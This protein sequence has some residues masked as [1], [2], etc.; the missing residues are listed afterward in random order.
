[1]ENNPLYQGQSFTVSSGVNFSPLSTAMPGAE[2]ALRDGMQASKTF[3]MLNDALIERN[4]DTFLRQQEVVEK[5]AAM[6]LTAEL[7]RGI[8]AQPGDKDSLYD[9][10][11]RVKMSAVN[12]LRSKYMEP[13]KYFQKGMISPLAIKKSQDAASSYQLGVDKTIQTA[14]LAAT[15]TK[16]EKVYRDSIKRDIMYGNHKS[17][18]ETNKRARENGVWSDDEA[19]MIQFDIN[20]GDAIKKINDCNGDAAKLLALYDDD[21]FQDSIRLHDKAQAKLNKAIEALQLKG[22]PEIVRYKLDSN[23]KPKAVVD[24]AKPPIGAPRYIQKTWVDYKGKFDTIEAKEAAFKTAERYLSEEITEPDT[25]SVGAEQWSKAKAVAESLGVDAARFKKAYDIRVSQISYGGFNPVPFVQEMVDE[26]WLSTTKRDEEIDADETLSESKKKNAK[27]QLVE[28]IR[29]AAINS[30]NAWYKA[31]CKGNDK[32]TPRACVDQM[33]KVL[34]KIFIGETKAHADAVEKM[35]D[36]AA[37]VIIAR[38]KEITATKD[39]QRRSREADAAEEA[40]H[41]AIEFPSSENFQLSADKTFDCELQEGKYAKDLPDTADKLILYVPKGSDLIN[42]KVNVAMQ[43]L[44][45][46]FTIEIREADVK[47]PTMSQALRL[48]THTYTRNPKSMSWDGHNLTFSKA[49]IAPPSWFPNDDDVTDDGVD[50]QG[51]A[52]LE[53]E[54]EEVEAEEESSEEQEE[55]PFP[56]EGLEHP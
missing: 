14:L 38:E 3:Q 2:K 52:E 15:K 21:S 4:D 27:E 43:G 40:K 13:A 17:A 35:T 26:D 1:M 39:R 50:P 49:N 18:S 51:A 28:R 41:G 22:T 9:E 53:A 37:N 11:G 6:E 36:A 42:E 44:K 10:Y 55:V 48:Q 24:K 25:T 23:G 7:Q 16:Q 12:A 31:N 45:Y 32:P 19:D 5:Q 34:N 54:A 56:D 47:A 20:E 8:E 29:T 33:G 46:A 30:Y